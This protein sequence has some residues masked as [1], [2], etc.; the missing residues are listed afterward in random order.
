MNSLEVNLW[1]MR[2]K[3]IHLWLIQIH[4]HNITCCVIQCHRRL[5]LCTARHFIYEVVCF[6]FNRDKWP[7]TF[8]LRGWMSWMVLNN[9]WSLIV[10]VE[11]VILLFLYLHDRTLTWEIYLVIENVFTIITE[12]TTNWKLENFQTKRALIKNF[13]VRNKGTT[14]PCGYQ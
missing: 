12:V 6:S 10:M 3:F 14:S 8:L 2:Y 5:Y 9:T 1:F 13:N 4:R 11:G 7:F